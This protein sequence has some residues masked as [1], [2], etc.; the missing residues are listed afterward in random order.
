MRPE[1]ARAGQESWRA[2]QVTSE[3]GIRGRSARPPGTWDRA[4]G[5]EPAAPR[6]STTIR[7]RSRPS[8][9]DMSRIS[10]IPFAAAALLLAAAAAPAQ[11]PL[12]LGFGRYQSPSN[13]EQTSYFS[14]VIVGGGNNTAHGYAVWVFPEVIIAV[15]VTSFGFFELTPGKTSFA[16]A[17]P[18]VGILGTPGSGGAEIGRTAFT[19]VNDNGFGQPDETAG[20]SLVPPLS[21]LPPLPPALGNLTTIQQIVALG[22]LLQVPPPVF[23][24]L[25]SGHIWVH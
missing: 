9:S 25:Q 24:P 12:S 4:T 19:A 1:I 15:D 10:R 17:G 11:G 7:R 5:I 18:I 22:Q 2:A 14:H 16:F 21:S 20:M 23:A 3:Y 6:S 8:E 13:P